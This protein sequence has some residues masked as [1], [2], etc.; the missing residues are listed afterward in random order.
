MTIKLLIE[1]AAP[2]T[3]DKPVPDV[4]I[5]IHSTGE[6]DDLNLANARAVYQRDAHDLC[7][8]LHD[9]LPG[10]TFAELLSLLLEKR[11]SHFKVP[12]GNLEQ[13]GK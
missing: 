4:F 6:L 11:A 5:S 10:G 9:A 3:P 1:K 12:F 8:T 7:E 2:I 13:K